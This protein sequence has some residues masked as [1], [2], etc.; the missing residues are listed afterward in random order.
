[1]YVKCNLLKHSAFWPPKT[2]LI[3]LT[4]RT[5]PLRQLPIFKQSIDICVTKLQK[6]PELSFYN[7]HGAKRSY[8]PLSEHIGNQPVNRKDTSLRLRQL[9]SEMVRISSVESAP[10][11]GYIVTSD[12]EHQS[13]TVDPR[14]MRR[15]FLSGF[16][17]SA[18]D[19]V[20]TLAKAALWTDGRYHLQAD[21]ELDC[22]WILMK[23]GRKPIPSITEWLKHEFRNRF[24]IRIG[25]DPKLVSAATWEAW[26]RDLANTSISLVAVRKNL[27][28]LIWQVGRPNYNSYAA[29]PLKDEYA[30]KT[31]QEKIKDIRL[32]MS[33]AKADAFVVTA[34][35]EIAWLFNIRGYDLPHTP[36]LRSYAIV[37]QGSLHLYVPKHKL[38]RSV[39]KHLKMDSCSHAE[40]V[41][42]HN[43]TCIW[44]DLRTMSQAWNKV[45]LPT[46]CGYAE[47]ASKEIYSSIPAEKRLPKASPI[48][49]LRAIKN[50]VEAEGMRR[51]H[52]RDGM[53]M[54][55]F[56]AYME[57]QISLDSE[58]WDEMQVSRV[59]NEFR[60]EQELNKGI[61]FATIAAYGAHAALPHYEPINLTNIPIGKTSTLVVD[62]GGQYLD[63]TTDVTRTLHF[64]KP[65]EEQKKAYTSVLIGSI[66]LSSLIFPDDLMSDQVDVLARK[67]LWSTGNDYMHG[68]GHGIGHFSSV[69]E[70]PISISYTGGMSVTLKPGYFLSNE[71]GFYKKGDFGVRLEN[72]L[73]VLTTNVSKTGQTFLKFRDV[74]LVPYEPKLI[75]YNMLTPMH[76][77]WLNK[78]NQRIREEI[79]NELKKH[80]RMKGFYWMMDKT[81]DIPEWGKVN[82]D[83]LLTHSHSNSSTFKEIPVLVTIIIIYNIILNFAMTYS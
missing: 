47:G 59:V 9:R 61:S 76:R 51:A 58:G 70:S 49:D 37:T 20:V 25:A 41:K 4:D 46:P 6:I 21:L 27:I 40:C 75:D 8:C 79:G 65:T 74:T 82:E 1:M 54:C 13:E 60:L 78:Y 38:L 68:T 44:N 48:I 30:G 35:D 57:E 33:L 26:E 56:L 5:S 69:H 55:D 43:E 12:D 31:W 66:Q 42:W 50:K 64:G 52:I 10:L 32:E 2:R 34:L 45:W 53:A 15:E 3:N 72:I 19:A 62:S 11:H 80:L 23:K 77:R 7:Y 39:E 17:G 67:P 24:N 81:K 16:Y 63:G 71:P 29:Y 18:G 28:D 14:D 83:I 73:E 36:V 22:N